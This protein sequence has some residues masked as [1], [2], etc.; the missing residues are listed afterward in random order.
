MLNFMKIH[1]VGAEFFHV[2]GRGG[3]G[4]GGAGGTTDVNKLIVAFRNFAKAPSH[5]P[6]D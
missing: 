5:V 2:D 1:K 6:P 3:G 4:G